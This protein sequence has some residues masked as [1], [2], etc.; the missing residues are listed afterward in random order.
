MYLSVRHPCFHILGLRDFVW[1]WNA[2]LQSADTTI[3]F[4]FDH[5]LSLTSFTYLLKWLF[6]PSI[7]A[8]VCVLLVYLIKLEV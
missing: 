3:Y 2:G 1:Y 4:E 5:F 7:N 6:N 8:G